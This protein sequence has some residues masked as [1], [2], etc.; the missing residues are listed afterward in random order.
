MSENALGNP[1]TRTGKVTGKGQPFIQAFTLG[2][3]TVLKKLV[4][5]KG[6]EARELQTFV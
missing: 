3:N 4:H 6:I 1:L 2:V 5:W